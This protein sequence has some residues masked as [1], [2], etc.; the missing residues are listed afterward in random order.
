[1]KKHFCLLVILL[2]S[3]GLHAANVDTVSIYSQSMR[4]S[5]KC[6]VI[7]PE[8]KGP[9]PVVYLL[10]GWTGNF[11]N[12]IMKVPGLK[13]QADE[14]GIMIV[15]PDGHTSS[16]YIDSPI[17][18]T[19]KYE[20]FIGKEVPDYID[21]HFPTIRDRKARA[22]TGLSM[23]GYGALYL[24]FRHAETFGAV[25]SMSGGVDL[26]P[27]KKQ[28]DISKRIGDSVNH[29]SNWINYSISHVIETKPK[30]SLAIIIDCGIDDQFYFANAELHK[31]MLEYKIQHD[32]IER[33]GKHDWNYWANAVKYQLVYFS[34]YF[35]KSKN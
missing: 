4:K 7:N 12:W 8:K 26:K 24:G 3:I 13:Q 29:A 19:M 17:D 22:I 21:A 27:L 5:F 30:D 20:T 10:H 14:L 18:S 11:S 34:N 25:G 28:Y 6:V 35:G 23:G 15:C 32:Y 31:K 2:I 9:L 33:P 16:W 1:M